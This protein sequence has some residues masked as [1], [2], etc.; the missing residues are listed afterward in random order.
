MFANFDY[1]QNNF[2]GTKIKTEKEYK[3]L[4]QQASKY[5]EKYT[6]DVDDNTK[7][8]E[9]AISEYLQGV[10]RQ[11]NM[12]SESISGAYS[13]SWNANSVS[14]KYSEINSLLSLYLG[15][16]YSSYGEVIVIN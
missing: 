11:G 15:D 7:S 3:Y 6:T 14:N 8:C 16:K 5:I 12:T 13:V 10:N 4:G 1:Y 2:G 9:C